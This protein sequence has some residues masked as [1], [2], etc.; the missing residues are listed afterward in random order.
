MHHVQCAACVC[1]DFCAVNPTRYVE[2]TIAACSQAR[3]AS[4]KNGLDRYVFLNGSRIDEYITTSDMLC[5]LNPI[6]STNG[7]RVK[8]GDIVT[9]CSRCVSLCNVTKT[10]CV[11]LQEGTIRQLPNNELTY[12]AMLRALALSCRNLDDL[13]DW[14]VDNAQQLQGDQCEEY[15]QVGSHP[16]LTIIPL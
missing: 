10:L 13:G 11:T 8:H 14:F 1:V 6:R 2:K 5:T 12:L 3:Q 16:S 9:W 4:K 15:F 7:R